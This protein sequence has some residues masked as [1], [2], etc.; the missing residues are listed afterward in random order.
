MTDTFVEEELA[1][2]ARTA[3]NISLLRDKTKRHEGGLWLDSQLR[4]IEDEH[5]VLTNPFSSRAA[6]VDMMSALRIL[7]EAILH[8]VSDLDF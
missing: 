4:S 5:R 8:D 6:K 3:V 2:L 7:Y 1:H